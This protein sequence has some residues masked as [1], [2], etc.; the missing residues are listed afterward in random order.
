MSREVRR[1]GRLLLLALPLL[2][3]IAAARY[4]LGAVVPAAAPKS[5]AS[6]PALH[7]PPLVLARARDR[8]PTA[9]LIPRLGPAR[10]CWHSA[11][12]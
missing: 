6:R 9:G 3:L 10:P 12:A 1:L 8:G 5:A 4:T 11:A 2:V 7:I